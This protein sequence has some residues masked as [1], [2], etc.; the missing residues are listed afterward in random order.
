MMREI[1]FWG[2]TGQARVLHEAL[3][4]DAK[5]VA[6]VDN[7]CQLDSSALGVPLLH[8]E[9]GLDD[10]LRQRCSSAELLYAVAVGGAR[11]GDR[12]MLMGLLA[13]RGLVA[14]SIIH[15]TAFVAADAIIG[16]GCQ[17]LAQAAVCTG[18]RLGRGV[19]VNTAASVDHDCEIEEGVHLAP[20]VCLA[21]EIS[22][23]KRA[24]VGIG[25]VILPRLTIGEDAIIGAGAVV[26]SNVPAGVKVVGN[27][28][29]IIGRADK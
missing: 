10:W 25:A 13:R 12:L 9:K 4:G 24:F 22:I 19:I 26:T 17:I 15:R 20:G 6:L 3:C 7:N 28:A 21:G 11:G 23:G 27:P 14:Y 16:D 18:S 2:A 5:L 29:R 8:G 1:L